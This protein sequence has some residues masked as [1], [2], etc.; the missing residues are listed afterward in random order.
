MR[1]P[2]P[3]AASISPSLLYSILCDD[4]RREANGKLI[5][6][7]LFETIGAQ[8]FPATHP[9]LYVVNGWGGG[10][11]TFTQ[12]TRIHGPDSTT[13]IQ[14]QETSFTLGDLRAKHSVIARFNNLPLA[15]PGEYAVEIL[16]N[17]DLKLRYPLLVEKTT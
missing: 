15:Q 16:L 4:V 8:E 14:D 2:A 17:G 7:G 1:K 11:G 10:V 3:V 9:A 13:L 6:L 5:L 12:Y